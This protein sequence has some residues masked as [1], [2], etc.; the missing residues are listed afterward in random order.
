[1]VSRFER[2]LKLAMLGTHALS[3][4]EA[5]LDWDLKSERAYADGPMAPWPSTWSHHIGLCGWFSESELEHCH[6]LP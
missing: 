5:V 2:T 3:V 1:M 6:D 4:W